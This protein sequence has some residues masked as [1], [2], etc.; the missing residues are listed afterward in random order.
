MHEE[1]DVKTSEGC[2]VSFLE[3][4]GQVLPWTTPFLIPVTCTSNAPTNSFP[5]DLCGD[6]RYRFDLI[7]FVIVPQNAQVVANVIHKLNKMY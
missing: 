2:L 6:E 1:S 3:P 4:A 5:S 7:L